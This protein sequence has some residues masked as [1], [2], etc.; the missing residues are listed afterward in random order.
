MMNINILH[1]LEG[2]KEAKGITVII[3]VFRAF[4]LEAYLFSQGAKVIYPIGSLDE[5]LEL[6]KLHPEYISFG[7][8]EGAKVEGFDYG[9]S[10]SSVRGQDLTDRVIIHTTSAGTQGIVNAKNADEII[11]GS[12]VN[13]SAIATYIKK[14]NPENVSLVC[15]GWQCTRDTAEDLLCAEYI[16]SLLEDK[17][18][19]DIEERALQLKELEGKKF[20]DPTLQDK[21]PAEDF[22]MC[23][24]VNIFDFVIQAKLENNGIVNRRFDVKKDWQ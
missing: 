13:A 3:D 5:A 15:M 2:A 1:L 8:R 4:S 22:W 14:K 24:K 12:L 6:K 18:M 21:F 20:F 17:P 10:P 19:Q 16:K 9:N 11:T 7:E 23:T